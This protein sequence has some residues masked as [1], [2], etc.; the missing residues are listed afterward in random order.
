MQLTFVCPKC[1]R[2]N[3][4]EVTQPGQTLH[5]DGCSWSRPIPSGDLTDGK[6]LR[7]LV[8]ACDDLWRQ[9]DF[10]QRLGLA[11]V[12]LGALLS[13]IAWAYYWPK[14]AIGILMGFAL[15][16]L[17]LYALMSDVLVCYRCGS[18]HSGTNPDADHPHFDLETAERYR[19]EAKRLADSAHSPS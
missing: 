1:Q 7:C 19:Q 17:V 9:K 16:D 13:T 8:C 12:G 14:T 5:C 6:P 10:P 3:R 18:R 15:L 11:M 4:C 2:P